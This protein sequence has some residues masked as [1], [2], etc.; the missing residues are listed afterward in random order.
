VYLLSVLI[1]QILDFLWLVT[2]GKTANFKKGKWGKIICQIQAKT[3]QA[4]VTDS[5]AILL[6]TFKEQYRT[7]EMHKFSMV[8]A[9]TGKDKWDHLQEEEN[10]A[11]SLLKRI[12]EYYVQN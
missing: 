5:D 2:E 7:A 8:R 10:A 6:Q 9:M 4:L 12:H 3:G 11:S 1:E